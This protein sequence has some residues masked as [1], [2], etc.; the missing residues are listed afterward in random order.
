MPS[1]A[2]LQLQQAL[3][4]LQIEYEYGLSAEPPPLGA[5]GLYP[6]GSRVEVLDGSAKISDP[7]LREP[8]AARNYDWMPDQAPVCS[9]HVGVVLAQ[10]E[11][12]GRPLPVHVVALD[13]MPKGKNV[14][15]V[16][17]AGLA[18]QVWVGQLCCIANPGAK[19]STSEKVFAESFP[20][21]AQR[22]ADPKDVTAS[23]LVRVM[24]AVDHPRQHGVVA[25]ICKV[26]AGDKLVLIDAQGLRDAKVL[27][28]GQ[29]PKP[30]AAA[31]QRGTRYPTTPRP[32]DTTPAAAKRQQLTGVAGPGKTPRTGNMANPVAAQWAAQQRQALGLPQPG[33]PLQQPTQQHHLLQ[34]Q[35]AWAQRQLQ[36]QQQQQ[37]RILQQQQQQEKNRRDAAEALQRGLKWSEVLDPNTNRYY[38]RNNKSG[39]S[40][41]TRPP[42]FQAPSAQS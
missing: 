36:Q 31:L 22:W 32:G 26:E 6:V 21:L 2:A 15:L 14:I 40:Q 8:L 27:P 39:E 28:P 5:P 33:Q 18:Q 10:L 16:D 42:D 13:H 9:G 12:P 11:A 37:Q 3:W 4:D 7:T 23:K 30:R 24:A 35:Q 34:Q 19:Y 1:S 41:W 38:Y 17:A 20:M 29:R 25:Y